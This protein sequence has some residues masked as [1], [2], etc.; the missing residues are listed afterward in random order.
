MKK[1]FSLLLVAFVVI[2]I[3]FIQYEE[4]SIKAPLETSDTG[5]IKV[6]NITI[7]KW[8]PDRDS[9]ISGNA[10]Y[11]YGGFLGYCSDAFTYNISG[12]TIDIYIL[13][14]WTVDVLFN[15]TPRRVKTVAGET[16][17]LVCPLVL[18]GGRLVIELEDMPENLTINVWLDDY[19]DRKVELRLYERW[20][21]KNG[22]VQRGA[23]PPL[24]G[25]RTLSIEQ[26]RNIIEKHGLFNIED[27]KR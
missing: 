3:L 15:R 9:Y 18:L 11:L 20:H 6:L 13:E 10:V 4:K 7:A 14:D 21:L 22:S 24:K 25:I 27:Q 16:V 1:G 23:Y 17:T 5:E 12:S 2:T 19:R 26:V 8:S